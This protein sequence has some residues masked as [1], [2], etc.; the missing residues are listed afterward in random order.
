MVSIANYH[1]FLRI[2]YFDQATSSIEKGGLLNHLGFL[3]L[4]GIISTITVA[5]IDMIPVIHQWIPQSSH[6]AVEGWDLSCIQ[7]SETEQAARD[8]TLNM[9]RNDIDL[10]QIL[11]NHHK[12]EDNTSL[13]EWTPSPSQVFSYV[14]P[15]Q[16]MV[17]HRAT[18]LRRVKTWDSPSFPSPSHPQLNNSDPEFVQKEIVENNAKNIKLNKLEIRYRMMS[19]DSLSQNYTLCVSPSDSMYITYMIIYIYIHYIHYI[20]TCIQSVTSIILKVPRTQMGC[21][22]CRYPTWYYQEYQKICQG[23]CHLIDKNRHPDGRW[24]TC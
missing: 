12:C 15:L 20:R 10:S 7:H 9:D 3:P 24:R 16:A 19:I 2:P 13:A 5:K 8:E 22:E 6:G 18:W 4:S 23:N 14:H 17:W 11:G 21:A 1:H